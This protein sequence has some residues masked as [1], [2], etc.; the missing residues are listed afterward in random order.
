MARYCPVLLAPSGFRSHKKSFRTKGII[1]DI[2]WW[3]DET[4]GVITKMAAAWTR[5]R[6]TSSHYSL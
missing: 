2:G 5:V 4:M 1:Y 3:C 6:R